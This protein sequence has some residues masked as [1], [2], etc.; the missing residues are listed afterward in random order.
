MGNT[1]LK[2]HGEIFEVMKA[3][4]NYHESEAAVSGQ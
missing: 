2:I 3:F 1:W 4:K